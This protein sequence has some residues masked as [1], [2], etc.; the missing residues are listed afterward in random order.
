MMNVYKKLLDPSTLGYFPILSGVSH[1]TLTSITTTSTRPRVERAGTIL[2]APN[3]PLTQ[4]QPFLLLRGTVV[5]KIDQKSWAARAISYFQI[6]LH[7]QLRML[8]DIPQR[9]RG[10]SGAIHGFSELA[11]LLK[12]VHHGKGFVDTTVDALLQPVIAEHDQLLQQEQRDAHKRHP[13]TTFTTT[14]TSTLP[15]SLHEGGSGGGHSALY[16]R[17]GR[18]HQQ[19]QQ[20]QTRSVKSNG[21]ELRAT[22]RGS[23]AFSTL[24]PPT[25]TSLLSS[26]TSMATMG[27][28]QTQLQFAQQQQ[29]HQFRATTTTSSV[30]RHVIGGV[31]R[32]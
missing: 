4:T 3:V 23:T 1:E 14:T 2:A 10:A 29:H 7:E 17:S 15:G 28:S 27:G 31:S 9:K 11:S 12:Q 13:M 19:Q 24:E 8:Y 26:M 21:L 18:A 16:H 22:S 5:V 32:R 6:P 25:P 20:L 30:S